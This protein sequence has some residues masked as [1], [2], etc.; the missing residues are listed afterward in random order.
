MAC[1]LLLAPLVEEIVF[2]RLF[3][4]YL[5]RKLPAFASVMLSSLLFGIAHIAPPVIAYATFLGGGARS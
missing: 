2:R 5:D 3:M 4:G 1:Y